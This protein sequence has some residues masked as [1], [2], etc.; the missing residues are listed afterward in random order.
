VLKRPET[1]VC[2]DIGLVELTPLVCRAPRCVGN[3]P[4]S[5]AK[6]MVLTALLHHDGPGAGCSIG[7]WAAVD[8]GD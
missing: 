6:L 8:V 2:G 3:I 4:G 1:I 5:S 7:L